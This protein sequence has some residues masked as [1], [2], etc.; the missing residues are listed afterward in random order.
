MIWAR[1]GPSR[2]ALVVVTLLGGLLGATGVTSA[3]AAPAASATFLL[4]D[5][6]LP[7]GQQRLPACD[8]S[9]ADLQGRLTR[10]SVPNVL[11]ASPTTAGIRQALLRFSADQKGTPHILL[12]C[13]YAAEQDGAAFAL[14]KDG[15]AHDDLALSAVSVRAFSRVLGSAGGVALLDLYPAVA[16]PALADAAASALR[17][18]A[19]AWVKDDS[20]PGHRLVQVAPASDAASLT[21]RLARSDA[22]TA[23]AVLQVLAS[24]AP[25]APTP[26][27]APA[28]ATPKA[29]SM[30]ADVPV[31]ALIPP[32]APAA[33]PA[34]A[35]VPAPVPPAA[36]PGPMPL[37]P[38]VH[39]SDGA[40][41]APARLAPPRTSVSRPRPPVDK[42]LQHVQVALLARG[43]Y[44]GRVN[45]VGGPA[46]VVAIRHFQA[47]IGHPVSG[48]ITPDE[49]KLLTSK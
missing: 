37:E 43:L 29:A 39:G 1:R 3:G 24:A 35:A 8:R 18:A 22:A 38:A 12:F 47:M 7:D 40:A 2:H 30:S 46:T 21:G 45:G 49:I 26:A 11:L 4:I 31:P 25:P 9:L 17:V 27:Q 41:H 23:D 5:G 36:V 20:L 14:G 13:G 32:P 34:P 6:G 28:A 33:A 19:T 44:L 42:T 10:G 16:D 48:Q 15:S